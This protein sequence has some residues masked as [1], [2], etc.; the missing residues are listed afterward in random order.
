MEGVWGFGPGTSGLAWSVTW[1]CAAQALGEEPAASAL[2][3][4]AEGS[5]DPRTPRLLPSPGE[6]SSYDWGKAVAQWPRLC[7]HFCS[8][9]EKKPCLKALLGSVGNIGLDGPMA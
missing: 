3:W 4:Q 8:V 5:Q 2:E 1:A 9:P 6:Q 7:L